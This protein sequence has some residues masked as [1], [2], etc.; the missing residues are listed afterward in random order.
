MKC[1][2]LMAGCFFC[3]LSIAVARDL[4]NNTNET[5]NVLQG[6]DLELSVVFSNTCSQAHVVFCL[7]NGTDRSLR[8]IGTSFPERDFNFDVKTCDGVS[9][10]LRA[11]ALF[12]EVS[13]TEIMR[14]VLIDVLPNS[15][16]QWRG[17]F[18]SVYNLSPNRWYIAQGSCVVMER[19]VDNRNKVVGVVKGRKRFK[20]PHRMR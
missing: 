6:V 3:V 17:D 12:E 9:V 14:R 5:Y 1:K 19:G 4:A 7:T 18:I 16:R 8:I 2:G 10:G 13:R 15:A 11:D 20:T